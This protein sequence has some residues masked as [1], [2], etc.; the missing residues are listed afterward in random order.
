MSTLLAAVVIFSAMLVH[1]KAKT[2]CGEAGFTDDE[3]AKIKADPY[4]FSYE[5]LK[6][7][8]ND[9]DSCGDFFDD[10]VDEKLM[11]AA[12][13]VSKGDESSLDPFCSHLS[14]IK[15]NI[16]T[17]CKRTERKKL[18][19]RDGVCKKQGG[20]EEV[21]EDKEENTT[22]QPEPAPAPEPNPQPQG[23]QEDKSVDKE[24]GTGGR[25]FWNWELIT[26]TVAFAVSKIFSQPFC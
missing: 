17:V 2:A 3:V 6:S 24:S 4:K 8:L 21:E 15:P 11:P 26:L 25:S 9:G 16:L 13:Q 23:K 18:A 12:D 19:C 10:W 7:G 5:T 1:T 14:T 20:S 22:S